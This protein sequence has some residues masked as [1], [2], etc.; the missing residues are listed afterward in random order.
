LWQDDYLVKL[1]GQLKVE[2]IKTVH[3]RLN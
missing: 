2:N 1:V 3:E